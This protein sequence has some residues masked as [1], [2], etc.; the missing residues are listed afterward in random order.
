MLGMR[1]LE[2]G[3]TLIEVLFAVTVF[4]FVVVSSLAIMNQGTAAAQRSLEI[5]LVRQQVD[6]QADSLRFLH[7]SYVAAYRPGLSYNLTDG[8]TS[9][10]EEWYRLTRS[11]SMVS[12]VIPLNNG[13]TSC[14]SAPGTAF[15]IN[16]KTAR[17]VSA[18][19][20]TRATT[21]SR[22]AY[23]SSGA[24]SAAQGLWVEAIRSGT[25]S[26]MNQ[27]NA[28][29]IDFHIR[30]CWEAPGTAA[31]MTIGTIVRLYEPRG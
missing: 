4:S 16:P 8:T 23:N 13:G 29:Y 15:I 2:R 5:S 7:D 9:P 17:Y 22:L 12:T 30:A 21:Y 26:D 24:L 25:S 11:P 3:D 31:P 1:R 28:G 14:S 19:S 18:S 10:A 6:A 20:L 27:Q